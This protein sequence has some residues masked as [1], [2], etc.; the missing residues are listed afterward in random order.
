VKGAR[1]ER[2]LAANRGGDSG[3]DDVRARLEG[4]YMRQLLEGRRVVQQV[5]RVM[6]RG[7]R[8]RERTRVFREQMA[9]LDPEAAGT[10]RR[11]E[12]LR[13]LDEQIRRQERLEIKVQGAARL[14][15]SAIETSRA[16]MD[17]VAARCLL[18]RAEATLFERN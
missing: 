3:V 17:V 14:T 6:D 15:D 13:Q 12:Q 8:L 4:A 2:D 5:G 9:D 18:A 10:A 11:M 1:G 7:R 16:E